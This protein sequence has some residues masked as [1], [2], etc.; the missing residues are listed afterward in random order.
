MIS[1]QIWFN[2]IIDL[3]GAT[4]LKEQG[5]T[6]ILSL[7]GAYAKHNEIEK[8]GMEIIKFSVSDQRGLATEAVLPIL[9]A[10]DD[11]LQEQ[12]SRIYIHCHAGQLRAPTITWLY[13]IYAGASEQYAT[14]RL[15]TCA[16]MSPALHLVR[17]L[18][19]MAIR[20]ARQ[21]AGRPS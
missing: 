3:E 7:V 8:L 11:A 15:R 2:G 21:E 14:D 17:N 9:R 6:H 4:F 18:D 19:I 16:S 13:L 12:G 10:I 20:K 1:K 5:V